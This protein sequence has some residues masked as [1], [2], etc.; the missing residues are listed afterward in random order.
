MSSDFVMTG[1]GTE[2]EREAEF[3]NKNLDCLSE[4]R[5]CR[6]KNMLNVQEKLR[7]YNYMS[8]EINALYHDAAVK[9]GISDS[10]QSILY[11]VCEN[12]GNCL[13]SEIYK[14][15]NISR[16]TINS[17]IRK[18]EQEG[19]VYLE[20]GIGR[21]TIVCLTDKGKAVADEKARPILDIEKEIFGEW[22]EEEVCTYLRLTE[23]YL[24]TL[25]QKFE[26][27]L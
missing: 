25:K 18:L 12:G 11:V 24:N 17:A 8:S 21:N 3:Q 14:Q 10:V 15:A 23:K 9:M 16:Q 27:L 6:R 20:Q 19:I 1:I 7:R 13:Q 4:I 22:T 2:I 5:Q 26:R